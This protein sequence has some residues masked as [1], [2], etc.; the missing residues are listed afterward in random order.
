[1][2]RA[3][4]PTV[5]VIA[6]EFTRLALG[7]RDGMGMPEFQPVFFGHQASNRL[8][9]ADDARQLA[10]AAFDRVVAVLTGVTGS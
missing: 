3:G 4:L 6:E 5:S 9:T 10:E 8:H 1:M 2:E 7:K